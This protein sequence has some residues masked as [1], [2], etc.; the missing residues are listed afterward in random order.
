VVAGVLGR[1]Q[2]L[3]D[4]WGDTVN[5]AA[6]LESHGRPGCVNLSVHAW[7]YI[8]DLVHGETRGICA[9]KGKS[10]PVEIIHLEPPTVVLAIPPS[11]HKAITGLTTVS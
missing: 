4:L 7:R 5:V 3:Y 2:S 10:K 9:L 11:Y 8:A 6:R 1:R